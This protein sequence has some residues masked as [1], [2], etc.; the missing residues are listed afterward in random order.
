MNLEKIKEILTALLKE[1]I[2]DGIHYIYTT[3]SP[4]E[5]LNYKLNQLDGAMRSHPSTR[6]DL[7]E[8][9]RNKRLFEE[10]M[11]EQGKNGWELVTAFTYGRLPYDGVLVFRKLVIDLE[12]VKEIEFPMMSGDTIESL[13]DEYEEKFPEKNAIYRNELTKQFLEWTRERI[14]DESG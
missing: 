12:D 3:I 9:I 1:L 13:I 6:A 14:E 8:R 2:E 10:Y 4:R 11:S 7:K 5:I